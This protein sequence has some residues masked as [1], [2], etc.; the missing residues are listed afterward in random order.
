MRKVTYLK[1]P[2]LLGVALL[3]YLAGATSA[4]A[5]WLD[6]IVF[7]G[8]FPFKASRARELTGLHPG[9]AFDADAAQAAAERLME[10]CR[11]RYYPMATVEWTVLFE[12]QGH[13][14]LI[15]DVD[16][17]P[18]GRLK[19]LQFDGNAALSSGQ[20]ASA[21]TTRPRPGF[22]NWLT[23]RDAL[24]VEHLAED[25]ER[26]LQ[27]YRELG[28][29]EVE[30]GPAEVEYVDALDG[31]R[32][33]WPILHEGPVYTVGYIRFRGDAL[34]ATE[35][36]RAII[37]LDTGAPYAPLR[38]EAARQRLQD[39][40][41]YRGHA[42]AEIDLAV[43]LLEE[44]QRAD[45]T[46]QIAAGTRPRL[47]E[48]SIIGNRV[49]A[50][51][52]IQ[53]EIPVSRG[54]VFD[55]AALEWA[56]QSLSSLPL[57]EQVELTKI[58]SAEAEVFD[59]VVT[60]EER[61]TGRAEA[62]FSYGE[63]EGSAFLINV[64]ERNLALRP[65]FRGQA[66]E[67]NL[68]L[69]AGSRILRLETG[70]R[71]PRVGTTFWSVDGNIFYEDNQFL[72]DDYDQRSHGG[73]LLVGHPIGR[74]QRLSTGYMTTRYTL[75]NPATFLTEEGGT[76]DADVHLTSWVATWS[77]DRVDQSFRPTRG[78]RSRAT[79]A[80][81][82]R[83]L[84]GDTDVIQA[85]ADLGLYFNPY[86]E[87]V[88]ILRGGIESADA[89]GQTDEVPLML[90]LFLGGS[91]N[92]RGF[93]YRTVSPQNELGRLVG[94]ESAWWGT[95]EYLYPLFT[96][97]DVAFYFDIGDVSDQPFSLAGDG[98]VSNSGVGFLVRA[99]NFPIRFDIATPL[100]TLDGDQENKV[101]R[102]RIS[103]S[104]GYLF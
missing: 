100:N 53:R 44:Q 90:R 85:V 97:M 41:Y 10:A 75:Y 103:F 49:T 20:L 7:R 71:N 73:R 48:I 32:I 102:T 31:F 77:M 25:R 3:I 33:I 76:L 82:S 67:A 16:P 47:Q 58:G 56:Q 50:A 13:A 80:L 28:H 23:G 99:D 39:Y 52:V 94:G 95:L 92:L 21:V 5:E 2:R 68:G 18:E 63:V 55:A 104:V 69:T 96:R 29:T 78:I 83:H 8:D 87:H 61:R 26:L 60:V 34:P 45:L 15:F 24:M 35:T 64:V 65:P 101:G 4:E 43:E 79:T 70:L 51:R 72:S 19:E 30:I 88:V 62:G 89:Y 74:T 22:R 36:L 1:G 84:G 37:A 42:F 14:R 9:E 91:R 86:R 93:A 98:P 11:R 27:L 38:V 40:F 6:E 81:G 12:E 17:G 54:G 59:L 57:F 46:F 66:L